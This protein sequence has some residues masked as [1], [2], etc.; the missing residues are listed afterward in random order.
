MTRP[1]DESVV[2]ALRVWFT[3]R[4]QQAFRNEGVS[5]DSAR[6]AMRDAIEAAREVDERDAGKGGR[7]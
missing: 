7:T 4:T 3:L 2:A 6:D 1:S 5:A